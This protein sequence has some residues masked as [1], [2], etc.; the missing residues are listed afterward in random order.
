L[1]YLRVKRDKNNKNV[2]VVVS[3]QNQRSIII[4]KKIYDPNDEY[5]ERKN[6]K[7]VEKNSNA[8]SCNLELEIDIKNI[9]QKFKQ[10]ERE[11]N[12]LIFK[13]KLF[14]KNKDC[15]NLF[16]LNGI[17]N[18]IKRSLTDFVKIINSENHSVEKK[19]KEKKNNNKENLN[20]LKENE[21]REINKVSVTFSNKDQY[22]K[23]FSYFNK[24]KKN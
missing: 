16:L 17:K 24:N 13:K 2:Y 14:L 21:E 12:N 10:Q 6:E 7:E 15:L 11:K 18:I 22:N 8:I 23:R 4:S 3:K 5:Q 19:I 20:N 9:I 1:V